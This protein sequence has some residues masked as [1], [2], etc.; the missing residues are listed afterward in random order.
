[1]NDYCRK[2]PAMSDTAKRV[3]IKFEYCVEQDNKGNLL[4]FEGELERQRGTA[5]KGFARPIY[6]PHT[7][8]LEGELN[9]TTGKIK[10]EAQGPIDPDRKSW[11]PHPTYLWDINRN[12]KVTWF[13]LPDTLCGKVQPSTKKDNTYKGRLDRREGK[14]IMTISEA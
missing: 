10:L 1:M 12:G 9:L 6:T 13:R 3:K 8:R 5:W 14:L 11:D 2:E 7:F 4:V